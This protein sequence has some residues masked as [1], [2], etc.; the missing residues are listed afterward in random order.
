[1]NSL[2]IVKAMKAGDRT[3]FDQLYQEY[4]LNLYRTAYLLL[5]NPHDAEDVLQE[6]FVS[7]YLNIGNLKDEEKLK[8]WLFSILK[9]T[10]YRQGKK[11]NKEWPDQHILLKVDS[12]DKEENGEENFA[13]K[14]EIKECLMNL[15]PKFREVIVLYYYNDFTIEE[16]AQICGSFQ[17]TIK[18][19]LHKARK[20]LKKEL[21]KAD[22]EYMSYER[23][24][25]HE[26]T[27][28]SRI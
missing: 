13:L 23:E 12:L 25:I 16:I 6:T 26:K 10:A 5:G 1:M 24:G 20:E 14:N 2:Q 17:G 4:H 15:K 9:H 3:G 18:S 19:R 22:M 11:R 8:S 27:L 7:A 21:E 28:E